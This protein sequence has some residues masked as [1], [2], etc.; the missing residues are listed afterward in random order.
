MTQG[1]YTFPAG[2]TR[3]SDDYVNDEGVLVAFTLAAVARHHFQDVVVV[4][5]IAKLSRVAQNSH[6]I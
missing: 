6:A 5:G 3:W 2:G 4:F 1:C